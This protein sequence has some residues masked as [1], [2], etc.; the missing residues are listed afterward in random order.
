MDLDDLKRAAARA[1]LDYVDAGMVVGVGSGTTTAFFIEELAAS[2]LV[3]SAVV[4]SSVDTMDRLRRAGL[5]AVDLAEAPAPSVY[6]DGADEV[7]RNLRLIKGRGGAL[8]REKLLAA[9]SPLFVCIV[10][11][12]KLVARLG[13]APVPVEVLP[14]ARR[15]VGDELAARGAI[16][17]ERPGYVTDNGNVILDV[18][19]LDLRD[20]AR[21]EVELDAMPGVLECG[22]FARRRAD[23]VLSAVGG[24]RRRHRV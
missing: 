3:L 2:G 10:D 9:V 19:G 14:V 21:L 7:D 17:A 22:V 15:F 24:W 1:A 11:E 20:P 6:V 18:T 23:V 5:P 13:A 16:A 8:A 4:P 12:T